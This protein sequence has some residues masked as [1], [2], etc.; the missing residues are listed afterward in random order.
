MCTFLCLQMRVGGCTCMYVCGALRKPDNCAHLSLGV[1]YLDFSE[2]GSLAYTRNSPN[3]L[4][5]LA[6]PNDIP[7]LAGQHGLGASC[8]C[9]SSPGIICVHHYPWLIFSFFKC[10]LQGS[11]S[12]NC[13]SPYPPS[14]SCDFFSSHTTLLS[15]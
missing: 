3:R 12:N 14:P 15:L 6:I 8:P 4:G 1:V 13:A 7:K 9:L 10:G 2:T 11:N 5:W